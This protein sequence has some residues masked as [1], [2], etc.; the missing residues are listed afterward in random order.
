MV[1]LEVG[2]GRE[3]T[4]ERQRLI[5]IFGDEEEPGHFRLGQTRPLTDAR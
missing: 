5:L 2:R 1:N 3:S 4:L